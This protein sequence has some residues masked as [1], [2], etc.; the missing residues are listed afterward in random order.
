MLKPKK[1]LTRREIKEDKLVTYYFKSV[2]YV[3]ENS[4]VIGGVVA[5]LVFVALGSFWMARHRA[6]K[7]AKAAVALAKAQP[8]YDSRN[9][10]SAIPSL[11]EIVE[12]YD[13]SRSARMAAFYLANAYFD[14]G[15]Y[16]KAMQYFES[17]GKGAR[18]DPELS[19]SSL[20]GVAAC[21]EEK[22]QYLEAASTYE[23]VAE[24][25]SNSF[26]APQYLLDAGRCYV[27]AGKPRDAR[28]VYQ[29]VIDKY[30]KSGLVSD[31]ELALAQVKG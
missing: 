31:A 5:A 22:R 9:Y 3:R 11:S 10:Q 2:D 18:R 15:D 14:Q 27:L 17:S 28:R 12:K 13:G 23:K 16:D 19:A 20:A 4:K 24:K 29:Q 26:L 6:E 1:K 7:E 25:Y 30:P 8:A 21:L